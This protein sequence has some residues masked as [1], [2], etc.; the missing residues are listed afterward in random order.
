M[1]LRNL[2]HYP[3]GA[4]AFLPLLLSDAVPGSFLSN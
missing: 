2:K 4:Q 3:M 1:M